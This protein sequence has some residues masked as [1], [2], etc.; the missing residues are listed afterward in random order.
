MSG[1]LIVIDGIDGSG[2]ATQVE[3]LKKYFDQKGM[4]YF[5]ISFPRYDDNVYGDLVRRYLLGEFGKLDEVD[6]HLA[7]SLYAG[8]RSLA[9]KEITNALN[10]GKVVIA[11]RYVSSSKAH[12]SANLPETE[13][14][15]FV[16][17]VDKLEYESNGMPREDLTIFLNVSAQ[18]GKEL[19]GAQDIHEDNLKHLEEASKIYQKL[20]R[21]NDWK[22]IECMDGGNLRTPEDIHQEIVQTLASQIT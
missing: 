10:S 18:K 2:K 11:D 19:S 15:E 22:V 16:K 17:W 14:E 7:A 12:L 9:K 3:L 5:G 1:K 20:A 13:R 6:P 21:G 8:D 4:P